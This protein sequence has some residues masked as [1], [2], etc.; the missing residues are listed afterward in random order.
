MWM[1]TMCP[2]NIRIVQTEEWEWNRINKLKVGILC[3]SNV[4]QYIKKKKRRAH[5]L[6]IKY[7]FSLYSSNNFCW[8]EYYIVVIKYSQDFSQNF[9]TLKT[10]MVS[11]LVNNEMSDTNQCRCRCIKTK[12]WTQKEDKCSKKC[13][14]TA[15]FQTAY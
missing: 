1:L 9:P 8:L 10:H 14:S 2:N 15:I 5:L 4:L 13:Y 12:M 7:Y 6:A 11:L 3:F